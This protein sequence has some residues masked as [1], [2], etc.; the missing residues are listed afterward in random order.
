MT[1]AENESVN[2]LPFVRKYGTIT[3]EHRIKD[4]HFSP[5]YELWEQETSWL[6]RIKL[7]RVWYSWDKLVLFYS[8]YRDYEKMVKTKLD[9]NQVWEA[10]NLNGLFRE[11]KDIIA[12]KKSE[13]GYIEF[14]ENEFKTHLQRVHSYTKQ[15][16]SITDNKVTKTQSH[17][18][19]LEG[20]NLTIDGQAIKFKA[21]RRKIAVLNLIVKNAKGIY[22]SE[23]EKE[24][25]GATGATKDIKN[26]CYE[27]CRGIEI[28]LAKFGITDFIIFD[29]NKAKINSIYKKLQI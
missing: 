18:F 29:F 13:P 10:I 4:W 22:F 12:N 9:N 23:E 19:K 20:N 3:D 21:D 1:L 28:R 14:Q 17:S 7:T 2:H 6:N 16:L 25:E 15:A 24:I 8:L 26:I 27:A 11:I 5:S